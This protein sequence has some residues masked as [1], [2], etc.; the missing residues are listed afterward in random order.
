M[1]YLLVNSII[2]IKAKQIIETFRIKPHVTTE[3]NCR[4]CLLNLTL[5]LELI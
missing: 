2:E 1:Q 5:F 4:K 3:L